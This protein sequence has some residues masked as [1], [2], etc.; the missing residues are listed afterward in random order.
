M[1]YDTYPIDT[2][3][4]PSARCCSASPFR[5][6]RPWTVVRSFGPDLRPDSLQHSS[7]H[8]RRPDVAETL[9]PAVQTVD[10]VE[11]SGGPDPRTFFTTCFTSRPIC[12]T[13][14][15]HLLTCEKYVFF[16]PHLHLREVGAHLH[17]RW[18]APLEGLHLS[19]F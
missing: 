11:K 8:R 2:H 18:G 15:E 14:S 16:L 13:R 5:G 9:L 1:I 10:A 6:I 4:S 12:I 3:P 7:V 19:A 17:L